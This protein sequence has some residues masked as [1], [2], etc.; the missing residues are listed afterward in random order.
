MF[1]ADGTNRYLH[2]LKKGLTP[3]SADLRKDSPA[4]C[5]SRESYF[6][7]FGYDAVLPA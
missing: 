1:M 5:R 7:K 4:I 2:R 6:Q 3:F